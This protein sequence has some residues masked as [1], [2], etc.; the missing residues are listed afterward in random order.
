AIDHANDTTSQIVFTFTIHSRHLC[1]FAANQRASRQSACARESTQKLIE[2]TRLKFFAA[3]VIEKKKW[4][5]TERRDVVY[6]MIY[7]VGADRVVLIHRD[8]N[9]QFRAD[10]VDARNQNGIE[11]SAKVCAKQSAEPANLSQH[12]RPVCL[13][14][15]VLNASFQLVAKIDIYSGTC[16]GFLFFH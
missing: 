7:K 10:A 16:V 9:F 14:H 3:D 6:A 2:H 12:L 8:R 13:L 15:E 4:A 5:R 1:R 11:H